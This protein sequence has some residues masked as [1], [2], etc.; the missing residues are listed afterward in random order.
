MYQA[1]TAISSRSS[2]IRCSRYL[3]SSSVEN[4]ARNSGLAP[5]LISRIKS[6]ISLLLMPYSITKIFTLAQVKNILTAP[7][8]QNKTQFPY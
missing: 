3:S 2:S 8:K 1:Q 6:I 7:E 4:N 5:L